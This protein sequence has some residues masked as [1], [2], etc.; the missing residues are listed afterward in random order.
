[1]NSARSPC[2][3]GESS[4]WKK[5]KSYRKRVG[6]RTPRRKSACNPPIVVSRTCTVSPG[7]RRGRSLERLG[8]EQHERDGEHAD[9]RAGHEAPPR[10]KRQRQLGTDEQRGKGRERVEVIFPALALPDI[11]DDAVAHPERG[12]E[13]P[14]AGAAPLQRGAERHRH[15]ERDRNPRMPPIHAPRRRAPEP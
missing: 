10:G 9:E 3:T 2:T 7:A 1:M 14:R 11:V 8:T 13:V 12:D 6:S 4:S 5:W 15:A